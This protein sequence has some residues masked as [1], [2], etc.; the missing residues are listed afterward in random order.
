MTT[1]TRWTVLTTMI[2][3]GLTSETRPVSAQVE[4]F[5]QCQEFVSAPADVSCTVQGFSGEIVEGVP[6]TYFARGRASIAAEDGFGGYAVNVSMSGTGDFPPLIRPATVTVRSDTGEECGV[7]TNGPLDSN[8]CVLGSFSNQ[9]T[10]FMEA[11][12]GF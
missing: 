4:T 8:F 1:G 5:N 2:C 12:S 11:R 3:L 9:F 6:L 7:G 10:V